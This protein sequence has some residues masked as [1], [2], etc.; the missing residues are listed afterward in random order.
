MLVDAK[1]VATK[2]DEQAVLVGTQGPVRP[3][4]YDTLPAKKA[5]PLPVTVYA[6]LV[7]PC[8]AISSGNSTHMHLQ[9]DAQIRKVLTQV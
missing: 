7:E 8:F 2:E 4:V 9:R 1:W 3:K 6:P 5:K